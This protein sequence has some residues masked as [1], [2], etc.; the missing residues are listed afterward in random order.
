ML[1]D[2][3]PTP[4]PKGH[5]QY[6]DSYQCKITTRILRDG[7]VFVQVLTTA[8]NQYRTSQEVKVQKYSMLCDF[9]TLIQHRMEMTHKKRLKI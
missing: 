4:D 2:K 6:A 8:V 9:Y 1:T 7:S 5:C 3:G